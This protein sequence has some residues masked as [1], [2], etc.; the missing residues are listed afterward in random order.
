MSGT[1][2]PIEEIRGEFLEALKGASPRILLKAPTGSGKSTGIPPM[3]DDA[4][5]GENGLI[6]VVQPRR[7]AAACWPARSQAAR[8]G[9]GAGSRVHGS[10]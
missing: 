8:L 7:M 5:L 2:L 4:G 9:T 10:F 6:V 3:M 1:S